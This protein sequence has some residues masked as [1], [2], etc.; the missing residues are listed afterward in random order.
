QD[1]DPRPAQTYLA[2]RLRCRPATLQ[3]RSASKI[4]ERDRLGRFP[5]AAEMAALAAEVRTFCP[6]WRCHSRMSGGGGSHRGSLTSPQQQLSHQQAVAPTAASAPDFPRIPGGPVEA[7]EQL[8]GLRTSLLRPLPPLCRSRSRSL[9]CCVEFAVSVVDAV[10]AAPSASSSLNHLAAAA[11]SARAAAAASSRSR[12]RAAAAERQQRRNSCW[13]HSETCL[14]CACYTADADVV[15][16]SC[17]S[18]APTSPPGWDS[19]RRLPCRCRQEKYIHALPVVPLSAVGWFPACSSPSACGPSSAQRPEPG[20]G[21]P[22]ARRSLL[23]VWFCCYEIWAAFQRLDLS[24]APGA[25]DRRF[26]IRRR[27]KVNEPEPSN[28]SNKDRKH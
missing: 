23:A 1:F 16:D 27:S 20:H 24:I 4:E 11:A 3:L 8:G 6:T 9:N 15:N 17:A 2:T 26:S 10:S 25:T 13:V 22:G 21:W 18:L 28:V 12:T 19:W 14:V 7:S 5:N